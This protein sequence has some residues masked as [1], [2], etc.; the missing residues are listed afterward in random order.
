MKKLVLAF[1][2]MV[3]VVA[4]ATPRAEAQLAWFI[5]GYLFGSMNSDD[6]NGS[7]QQDVV[8]QITR[9]S[10]RVTDPL[11][12]RTTSTGN[13]FSGG[14]LSKR[15][16]S[17]KELFDLALLKSNIAVETADHYTILRIIRKFSFNKDTYASY[18]FEYISNEFIRDISELD[19]RAE[20]P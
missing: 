3:M 1:V 4:V 20:N 6:V 18:W 19:Q 12:V 8:Y 11:E 15:N 2:M 14:K 7:S 9:V 10:E 16:F 13:Y 17:L 5:G